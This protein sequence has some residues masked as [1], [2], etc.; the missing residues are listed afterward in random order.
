MTLLTIVMTIICAIAGGVAG[1][2]ISGFIILDSMARHAPG[3]SRMHEHR[4]PTP[5][6]S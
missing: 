2:L 3:H 6:S 5:Q 4:A 1:G